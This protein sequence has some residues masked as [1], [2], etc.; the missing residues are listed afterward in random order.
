MSRKV[1]SLIARKVGP[2]PPGATGLRVGS[3]PDLRRPADLCFRC[4]K[5]RVA[6][7]LVCR[8]HRALQAK[9]S[10]RRKSRLREAGLCVQCARPVLQPHV[11]CGKHLKKMR[12]SNRV[13]KRRRLDAGLCERCDKR[14]PR[15]NRLCASHRKR[16][17]EYSRRKAARRRKADLCCDKRSASFAG[18]V[19]DGRD[20]EAV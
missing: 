14:V 5:K 15:G 17:R 20:V 9:K 10:R 2:A 11:Y 13:L 7:L 19:H 1:P 12:D 8:D 6:G 16:E 18:R 3:G 4:D